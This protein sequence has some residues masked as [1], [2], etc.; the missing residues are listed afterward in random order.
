LERVTRAR[1]DESTSNLVRHVDS[2]DHKGGSAT[3]TMSAFA[4]GSTY[5]PGTFRF[6]LAIWIA[7]RHR[8]FAIVEDPEFVE[9]LTSL[10]NT[11][12][13]PSC[14]TVSRDVQ[15]IFQVSQGKVAAILQVRFH[16]HKCRSVV[17]EFLTGISR[18]TTPMH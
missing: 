3:R 5:N 1:H 6:K 9:L 16:D 13:V 10:N 2:C 4:H 15:E 7:K 12:F 18:E 8:P 14:S 17:R 11:V